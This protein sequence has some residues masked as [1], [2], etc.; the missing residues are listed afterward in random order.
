[1]VLN[2]PKRKRFATTALPLG[3]AQY[4]VDDCLFD[5]SLLRHDVGSY[6]T[7]CLREQQYW[8]KIWG[9]KAYAA[10]TKHNILMWTGCYVCRRSLDDNRGELC[11]CN[12]G[13]DLTLAPIVNVNAEV[14][15]WFMSLCRTDRRRAREAARCFQAMLE[16]DRGEKNDRSNLATLHSVRE[17]YSS[18]AN[19]HPTTGTIGG[20][21]W[22]PRL[23]LL[24][25][26]DDEVSEQG[27]PPL[28]SG[29]STA[30]DVILGWAQAAGALGVRSDHIEQIAKTDAGRSVG[31]RR[32]D[33]W[34]SSRAVN[35]ILW[36]LTPDGDIC[37]GRE[38]VVT[39]KL[40]PAIQA[41]FDGRHISKG[42]D[43]ARG[44]RTLTTT[45]RDCRGGTEQST[46]CSSG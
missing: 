1:M 45:V 2:L 39:S 15:S 37:Q 28:A 14:V 34:F 46:I 30:N 26:L 40:A 20:V 36:R 23:A 19:L 44:V 38:R 5:E 8:R 17:W 42:F 43:L 4:L 29:Q 24:P 10:C 25:L 12:C 3:G 21:I 31:L 22:H 7:L 32:S 11:R 9:L 13:A 41:V 27:V 18:H 6:C 33:G 16:I 35:T